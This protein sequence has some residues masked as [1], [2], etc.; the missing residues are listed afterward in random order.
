MELWHDTQ[1]PRRWRRRFLLLLLL[2]LLPARAISEFARPMADDFG[3][4]SGH[5]RCVY[6]VRL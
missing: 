5:S 1:K 3:Y 4:S 6:A 2:L